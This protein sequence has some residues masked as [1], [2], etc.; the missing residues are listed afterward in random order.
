MLKLDKNKRE[1][2]RERR[3][4]EEKEICLHLSGVIAFCCF[5]LQAD[6]AS[7]NFHV[8]LLGLDVFPHFSVYI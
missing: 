2:E 1:R 6:V 7:W 5:G 8:A 3:K 4:K